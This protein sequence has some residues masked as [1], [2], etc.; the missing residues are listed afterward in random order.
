MESN[1]RPKEEVDGLVTL[2]WQGFLLQTK[3]ENKAIPFEPIAR[4]HLQVG[5]RPEGTLGLFFASKY[6]P[7][8]EELIKDL[9]PIRILLFRVPE[10]NWALTRERPLDMLELVRWKWRLA[11]KSGRPDVSVPEALLAD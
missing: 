9:R 2:G 3:L 8:A 1:E 11:L 10:M 5:R 6:S 4:L 7:A